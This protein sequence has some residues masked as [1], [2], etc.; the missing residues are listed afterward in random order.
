MTV[1]TIER[2]IK[3]GKQS[4]VCVTGAHGIMECQNDK[5]LRQIHNAAG[6]VTPDGMPLVWVAR[7]LGR[8]RIERVYGPDLMRRMTAVS[9]ERAYRQFYYGGAPHVA[10][11]LRDALTR[12]YPKLQVADVLCPPFR[13]LTEEEEQETVEIINAAKP[14]IVWVGLE[15]AET[16]ILDGGPYQPHPRARHDRRRCRL[17][18]PGRHQAPGAGVGAADRAGMDVPPVFRTAPALAPLRLYRPELHAPRRRISDPPCGP[19]IPACLGR[20]RS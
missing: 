16:G 7:L 19:A 15:Y 9:A 18:F 4:Y 6:M 2:W 12:A 1:E 3:T 10:E 5:R 20:P 14:D 8:K 11:K 17:R 13:E